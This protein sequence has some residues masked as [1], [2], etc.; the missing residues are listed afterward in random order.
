MLQGKLDST[1]CEEVGRGF[2]DTQDKNMLA[3]E[4]KFC[5]I[6]GSLFC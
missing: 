6:S 3:M 4:G 1:C 5:Y 2:G